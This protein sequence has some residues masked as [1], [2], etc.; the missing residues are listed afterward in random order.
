MPKNINLQASAKLPNCKIETDYKSFTVFFFSLATWPI[1]RLI[2]NDESDSFVEN[3]WIFLS[4]F[5]CITL[6]SLKSKSRLHSTERTD[7]A[8]RR[9]VI[10]RFWWFLAKNHQ[11]PANSMTWPWVFCAAGVGSDFHYDCFDEFF[12]FFTFAKMSKKLVKWKKY[13]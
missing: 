2:L 6:F 7:S 11:K 1:C 5:K 9:H 4:F 8:R 10:G 12:Y 13:A 3:L